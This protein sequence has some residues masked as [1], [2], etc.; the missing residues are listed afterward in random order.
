MKVNIAERIK[1]L[2]KKKNMTQKDLADGICSQGLISK[3][4]KNEI[5]PDLDVI[6]QLANRLG[7]SVGFL[8][9]EID[10]ATNAVHS[11]L[12]KFLE[13]INHFLDKNEYY[14]LELYYKEIS[15]DQVF[16]KTNKVYL[17]WIESIVAS[18][19]Y[20]NYNLALKLCEEALS[21]LDDEVALN[22]FTYNLKFN[23]L[24]S[25]ACYLVEKED[26]DN[27]I[28]LFKEAF[29]LIESQ[30]NYTIEQIK[31]LY[32]L[33]RTYSILND[34]IESN[35]YAERAL[36]LSTHTENLKYV[37]SIYYL[38][39]ENF[40]SLKKFDIATDYLKKARFIAEL[41]NN[42]F[43]YPYINRSEHKIEQYTS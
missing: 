39:T 40:I 19:N 33:A 10:E 25:K 18:E 28:E 16:V 20:S 34:V 15:A 41:K 37:D 42:T 11:T 22:P 31:L 26:Y 13:K 2:R 8:I 12:P 7:I 36:H 27:G 23:L 3:I 14:D 32:G 5:S 38:L 17:L 43:L 4:E 24:N 1:T 30:S 35:F 6:I 21:L 9:G 29:A